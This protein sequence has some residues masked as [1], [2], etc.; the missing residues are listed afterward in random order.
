[1][2]RGRGR[3]R[4]RSAQKC[5][6]PSPFNSSNASSS[7]RSSKTAPLVLSI[8]RTPLIPIPEIEPINPNSLVTDQGASMYASWVSVLRHSSSSAAERPDTTA[9]VTVPLESP[10][11]NHESA[12]PS[13][14]PAPVENTF[15]DMLMR[16]CL[17]DLY[18][19]LCVG[20]KSSPSCY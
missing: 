15:D 19:L 8:S 20:C 1:M 13:G 12:R 14:I 5:L 7:S 11:E 10:Q 16:C 17:E 18:C 2:A 9:R 3:P 6:S 4:E